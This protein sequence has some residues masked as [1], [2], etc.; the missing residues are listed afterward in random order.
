MPF[1]FKTFWDQLATTCFLLGIADF[2]ISFK[3]NTEHR[4]IILNRIKSKSL[5]TVRISN[6]L[7]MN[8]IMPFV[9]LYS[10]LCKLPHRRVVVTNEEQLT[11]SWS[12]RHPL[13]CTHTVTCAAI[14]CPLSVCVI[15]LLNVPETRR[16]NS[17]GS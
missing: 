12:D 9:S 5:C 4:S 3:Q 16:K 13:C 6:H 17:S 2:I 10:P 11:E 14:L 8:G 15:K 1:T 7:Q